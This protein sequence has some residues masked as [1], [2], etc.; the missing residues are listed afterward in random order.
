MMVMHPKD[1][2]T[3]VCFDCKKRFN[4]V[5]LLLRWLLGS[6]APPPAPGTAKCPHCGSTNVGGLCF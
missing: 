4:P 5:P 6:N 3:W 1:G 2:K